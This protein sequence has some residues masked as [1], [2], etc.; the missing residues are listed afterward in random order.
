MVNAVCLTN[1]NM[2][3]VAVFAVCFGMRLLIAVTETKK[4]SAYGS[5]PAHEDSL[6]HTAT[7]NAEKI[8]SGISENSTDSQPEKTNIDKKEQ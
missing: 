5:K 7:R 3:G 1:L 4:G 2:V 6:Q 8:S